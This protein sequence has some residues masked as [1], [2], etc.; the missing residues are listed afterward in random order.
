MKHEWF[1]LVAIL[2]AS[3]CV[4]SE[5]AS[6]PRYFF[7]SA[8]KYPGAALTFPNGANLTQIV[9]YYWPQVAAS[10]G[11]TQAGGI[12]FTAAPA[13]SYSSYLFSVNSGG[14][15][16]GGYCP[17]GTHCDG[18]DLF[19]AHGYTYDSAS[20]AV[21]T[22]DYPG[23]MSTVAYGI[24]DAGVLVGGF[25]PTRPLCPIGLALTSDH[26]FL[27]DHGVFTQLDFPGATETTA[28]GINNSGT[29]VGIYA[30]DVVQHSFIYENGVYT[31]LNFPLA[32]WT[33][34]TAINDLGV[35]VG[36]YQ[37]AN[38]NVNG[39]MYFE[40]EWT[41]INVLPGN[42]TAIVGINS[43]DD[44]VGTWTDNTGHNATFKAIP[45]TFGTPPIK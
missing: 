6:V 15:S 25:C 4:G 23:S 31:D 20:G 2:A 28:F 17:G 11:Y 34:A 38:I 7:G 9:G 21:T 16:A 42:T 45:V 5:A 26:G 37:D 40:G 32:N 33:D 41:K 39:F 8:G 19:A 3:L 43:H 27:D 44:L 12:F 24:N 18:G 30:N 13:N 10:Q 35:I 1:F 14:I 22:I 36:Y 29:I